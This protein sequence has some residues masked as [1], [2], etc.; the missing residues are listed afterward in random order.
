MDDITGIDIS[1]ATLDAF[2]RSTGEHRQFPN[3]PAGCKA[4]VRWLGIGPQ[5]VVFEPIGPYHRGLELA[6]AKAG[7]HTIKVNPRSARRFAEA[8]GVLAKT[9][10]IDARGSG[11]YGRHS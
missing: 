9:D 11:G 7:L 2:R 3:D 1:K 10:R 6:L 8:T 5:R 4:L